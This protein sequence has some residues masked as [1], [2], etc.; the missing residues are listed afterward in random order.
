MN[1]RGRRRE[2]KEEN[3]REIEKAHGWRGSRFSVRLCIS[4]VE[5]GESESKGDLS[6]T[7]SS[8]SSGS[9]V[10][11]LVSVFIL[12]CI[13]FFTAVPRRRD[14]S[15]SVCEREISVLL[16][17]GALHGWYTRCV[18]LF[19]MIRSPRRTTF[20]LVFFFLC[21]FMEFHP[22]HQMILFPS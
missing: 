12:P 3:E 22:L 4:S 14:I 6:F 21:R 18:A 2:R 11:P 9:R 17:G 16:R 13:Y 20:S 1:G 15:L 5:V 19:S 7:V 8:S 10:P